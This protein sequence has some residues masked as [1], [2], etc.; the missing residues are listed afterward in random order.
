MLLLCGAISSLCVLRKPRLACRLKPAGLEDNLGGQGTPVL[1]LELTLH[2]W[3]CIIVECSVQKL[4]DQSMMHGFAGN[5]A[6]VTGSNSGPGKA[7]AQ[8]PSERGAPMIPSGPD[9]A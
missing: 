7:A 5:T 1:I 9:S 6:L 8:Q 3:S 2:L 4:E